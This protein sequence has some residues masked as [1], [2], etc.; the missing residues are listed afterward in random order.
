[1]FAEQIMLA[2]AVI[3]KDPERHRLVVVREVRHYPRHIVV[4]DSK[5]LSLYIINLRADCI[6]YGTW[7]R[8]QLYLRPKLGR[9]LRKRRARQQTTHNYHATGQ[10]VQT[11]DRRAHPI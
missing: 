6:D 4:E 2:I 9:T 3:D 5:V 11:G 10:I 8:D 7:N 1:V